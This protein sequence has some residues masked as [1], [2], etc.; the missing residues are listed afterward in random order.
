LIDWLTDL[1]VATAAG[2]AEVPVSSQWNSSGYYYPTQIAQYALSHYSKYV[3]E[4]AGPPTSP[5][6]PPPGS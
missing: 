5:S 2:A 1:V 4:L 6:P 3:V